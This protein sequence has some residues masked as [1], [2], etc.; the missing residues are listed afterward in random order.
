[1]L[2]LLK[3]VVISFF[4]GIAACTLELKGLGCAVD[5]TE[6]KGE[7]HARIGVLSSGFFGVGYFMFGI[8]L[9]GFLMFSK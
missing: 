6:S 8:N 2:L 4:L 9:I 3:V 7:V 5:Y 1:M